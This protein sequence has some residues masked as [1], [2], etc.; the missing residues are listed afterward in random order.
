MQPPDPSLSCM[1]KERRPRRHSERHPL[2]EVGM[3]ARMLRSTR[4]L[5]FGNAS[6]RAFA[7]PL[8]WC[9]ALAWTLIAAPGGAATPPSGTL[10]ATHPSV[11]WTG[12]VTGFITG[13]GEVA[14]VDGVS[15]DSF[16]VI[17]QPGDYTGKQ[18]EVQVSWALGTFDY[19]LYVHR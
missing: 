7:L 19:D 9:A 16:E 11:S 14:C 18:L 1:R 10:D 8:A 4:R 13:V 5:R 2:L 12:S 6:V 15:C 17:V 3:S